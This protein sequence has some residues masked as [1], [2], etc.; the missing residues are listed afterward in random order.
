MKYTK[1]QR[2]EIYKK[3]LYLANRGKF[4]ESGLCKLFNEG[5]RVNSPYRCK[6]TG[7]IYTS[8]VHGQFDLE[9]EDS[10]LPELWLF[11][12]VL[13]PALD[14]QER[15]IILLFCIEMTR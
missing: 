1:R 3:A 7:Y 5:C 2:H 13:F 11:I 6:D 15:K 10:I 4:T 8:H 14:W 9:E 12:D